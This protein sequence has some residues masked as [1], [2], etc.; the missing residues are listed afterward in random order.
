MYMGI[1]LALGCVFLV[2]KAFEYKSKIDHQ[3]L[4]GRVFEKLDGPTGYRFYRT[5]E[6]Q[7]KHIVEGHAHASEKAREACRKLLDELP[8]LSPKEIN[9]RI[10]GSKKVKECDMPSGASKEVTGILEEF[11]DEDLHLSH[12]IP[13]GNMWASCYFAMTGFHALHVLGGLVVF[14]VILIM[15]WMGKFGV[16]HLNLVEYTGLYWHF[17]DIV[18]IFLFP[19]LYLV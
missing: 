3:I 14:G 12:S 11:H 13:F 2:V 7:L 19:L 10:A 5:V 1:T 8:R 4:P 15:A 6:E 16:Q 17:V 9:L 18:W